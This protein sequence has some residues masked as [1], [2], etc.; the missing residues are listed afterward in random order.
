MISYLFIVGVSGIIKCSSRVARTH[1]LCFTYPP[2]SLALCFSRALPSLSFSLS[3]WLSLPLRTF[4]V[5]AFIPAARHIHP[6]TRA[7]QRSDLKPPR[8]AH[9]FPLARK[10][11]GKKERKKEDLDSKLLHHHTVVFATYLFLFL[12]SRATL[13]CWY[14]TTRAPTSTGFS[15]LFSF[16]YFCEGICFPCDKF[17]KAEEIRGRK[18]EDEFNLLLSCLSEFRGGGCIVC[19]CLRDKSLVCVREVQRK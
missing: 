18:K 13:S 19:F 11:R 12:E 1:F 2:R 10:K 17:F 9:D 3:L 15:Y 16:F 7:E 5:V 6:P 4:P 14:S 8:S